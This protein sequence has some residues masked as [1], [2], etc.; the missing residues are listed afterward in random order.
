MFDILGNFQIKLN[1][2]EI[3]DETSQIN[4]VEGTSPQ[5]ECNYKTNKNTTVVWDITFN[6]VSVGP[7]SETTVTIQNINRTQSILVRCETTNFIS[8]E[9]RCISI[10]VQCKYFFILCIIKQSNYLIKLLVQNIITVSTRL[11]S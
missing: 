8:S 7:T 10:D 9:Y 2:V 3:Q 6:G 4:V 5:L 1:G 11:T